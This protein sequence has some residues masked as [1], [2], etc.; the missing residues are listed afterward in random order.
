MT[1]SSI[2]AQWR[3][4]AE[5]RRRIV[6]FMLLVV[7]IVLLLLIA[8]WFWV[9]QPLL[10]RATPN[11]V[12]TVDPSRLEAHVRKLSIEVGPRDA[13]H[14]GNLDNAAA[15]IK[16]E[17]SQTT[18]FVSEQAYRVQGRSY[19]NVIAQFGPESAERIVVGAHYDTAGPLPGADDN[20]SGVAGLIELARLLGQHAPP[21]RVELVAFSLE[22]PP[23]FGTTGMGS[24]VHAK[25]LREQNVRVR[26]MFSLE[27]IGCFSD[28]PGSQGFPVGTLRAF[29]PSTG[30]FIAVVGRINEGLLVR[31]VKATMRNAAPLPVYSINAPRSVPGVD[32]SD[33]LNYWV[34]GY[35]AVMITDTAFY[36]NRH[37][38]TA[39]DTAEKLDYKRMAMVVE[40]VYAAVVDL[41]R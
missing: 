8:V 2:E 34:A 27:M 38:H 22:E 17:F 33:Q 32:F 37:Y 35:N 14:T 30:N 9:T 11:A 15:Y 31:R 12:R 5:R 3:S 20:A 23:Y 28:A 21:I 41:A 1:E 6:K 7:V 24:S 26:A 36:R 19:R 13:S 25:S 18:T 16:N 10:S 40:G 29:Y 4:Q 39:Q